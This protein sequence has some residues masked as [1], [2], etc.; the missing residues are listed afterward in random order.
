MELTA[1]EARVLGC[2]I[3]GQVAAPDEYALTLDELR[4][5]CNQTSGRDPVV[6]Y[7][8]RTVE[9]T[10]LSLKSKGLA[11][12]VAAGRARGP[13][14]YRHRAD[15]RWRL[16]QSE[17]AVLAV[18]ILR[19]P[20]TVGEVR[21]ALGGTP[22]DPPAEVEAV[23]DALAGRTPTP[24]A[25]RLGG[26]AG[27]GERLWAEALTG[28]ATAQRWADVE[29]PDWA[30]RAPSPVQGPSP[31]AGPAGP[32][33]SGPGPAAEPLPWSAPASGAARP[34]PTLTDLA[35]RLTNI[36]RR[37]AGIET[38]LG[39]LRASTTRSAPP[40]QPQSP[41]PPDRPH[42]APSEAPSRAHR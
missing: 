38:A 5:A 10:L 3:E 14:E 8:D 21:A 35:D 15:E 33:R 34:A 6:A 4:F 17:L 9:D 23:L 30:R 12:F 42:Q 24:F 16:S 11:R 27:G 18:L 13:V 7:D 36:E 19:G 28:Q 25:I 1:A 26:G 2:L 40:P 37:L 31:S 39:A 29:E 22:L 32:G 41:R 20:Q